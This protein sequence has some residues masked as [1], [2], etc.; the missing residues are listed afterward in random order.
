MPNTFLPASTIIAVA[1][2]RLRRALILP[3]LVTR[4]GISDFRGQANDT[5]NV[6]VPAILRARE[7]TFRTRSA[8]IVIDTLEEVTVPVTLDRHPYSAVAVTDEELTLD[9][10]SFTRQVLEPQ[11]IAVAE[12]LEAIIAGIM[13]AGTYAAAPIPYSEDPSSS[14]F[15]AAAVD[16]RRALN[17]AH[18]PLDG[19]TLL[20]GSAIE[21]AALK[22]DTLR[23]VDQSGSTGALRNA[24]IGQV[25]GFT[26]VAS[27]SVDP[28]FGI[29]FHRSAFAFGNVAPEVP[30]GVSFGS[31][32]NQE[33]LAMRWIR[34][35][36]ATMLQDRSVV[37]S[38]AGGA[39]VEDGRDEDSGG[40]PGPLNNTNVRAVLLDFTPAS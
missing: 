31:S 11:V 7:Y 39:S 14:N 16:A 5:I 1:L 9:I 38:F 10:V 29:A 34:D 21:A 6:R 23:A 20:V 24:T 8:P 32:Q 37:N 12:D 40:Q 35:Y 2:E 4:Y 25:A 17:D 15:F 19:R 18:V 33:G 30:A 28:N 13:A 22:E 27:Q 3:N 36:D 26:V